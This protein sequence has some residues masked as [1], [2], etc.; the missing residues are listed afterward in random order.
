MSCRRGGKSR[1][2]R[3]TAAERKVSCTKGWCCNCGGTNVELFCRWRAFELLD[4]VQAIV[5][6]RSNWSDLAADL[7]DEY[8]K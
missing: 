3:I 6:C 1:S 5:C 7:L 8:S 2:W 4:F